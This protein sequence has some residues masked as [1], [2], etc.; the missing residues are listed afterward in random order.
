MLLT[1]HTRRNAKVAYDTKS[2]L[3]SVVPG[4]PRKKHSCMVSFQSTAPKHLF[5][6]R[7]VAIPGFSRWAFNGLLL[8]Y[9]WKLLRHCK[10]IPTVRNQ[11]FTCPLRMYF[12][13]RTRLYAFFW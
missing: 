6:S 5:L 1:V 2:V 7:V 4:R 13:K 12:L 3:V 10:Y 8:P 9:L 11:I